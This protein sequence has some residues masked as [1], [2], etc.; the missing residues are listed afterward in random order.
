[1]FKLGII[2]PSSSPWASPIVLVEKKN[3]DVYFLCEFLKVESRG[4]I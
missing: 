4:S 2:Q 1:M 3:G